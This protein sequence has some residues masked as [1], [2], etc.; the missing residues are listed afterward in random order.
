MEQTTKKIEKPAVAAKKDTKAVTKPKV[1]KAEKGAAAVVE[2]KAHARFIRMSPRKIRVVINQVRGMGIV[3]ALDALRFIN[4][5]AARPVVKLLESAVANADH[6]FHIEKKDLF[7]K[8]IIG[9]EGPTLKRSR[10]RA[11]GSSASILKKTCHISVVLGVR[12]GAVKKTGGTSQKSKSDSDVKVVNPDEIKK[13]GPK[14]GSK[15]SS[16]GNQTGKISKGFMQ[17]VF[18]RKTG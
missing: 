16:S 7:I 5:A 18:Q 10:P 8:K 6:N 9:N 3:E 4:R 14:S 17:G 13:S 1:V 11:H 12:V 2:V 15:P